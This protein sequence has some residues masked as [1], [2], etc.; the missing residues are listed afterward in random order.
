[1]DT[2]RA[3]D[4]LVIPDWPAPPQ[5]R[6]VVTTRRLPGN[7]QPPFDAFNLGLRSG[8]SEGTV[9]ANRELLVRALGLPS[10]PRWLRQVH[11]TNVV[12]FE[13]VSVQAGEETADEPEADAGITREP[14]AVLAI[15]SADCLPI[16]LC[17]EDGSEI[18]A[19]HA[20]WRGLSAGVI[21]ACVTRMHTPPARLMAW[22]GPAIG[23]QSYEVGDEVRTAFVAADE[24]AVAAFAPSRPAHWRCDLNALAHRR[25]VA[26]GV[27]RVHGGGF[28][29]LTDP[30][31]YSYRRDRDRSG[32]F[33]SLIYINR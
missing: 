33:A 16:L 9:R 5:V 8:E 3:S 23:P 31:F 29:T 18:A 25:L 6:A 11:G 28:D 22:L 14:G 4:A 30:R 15:L 10:A 1:M 24:G 27:S 20:G 2:P 13:R 26:L 19:L 12:T 32:R 21:E 7:S 17:A